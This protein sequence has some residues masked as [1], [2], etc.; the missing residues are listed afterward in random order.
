MLGLRDAVEAD[1]ERV[2][3]FRLVGRVRRVQGRVGGGVRA[4]RERGQGLG[5]QGLGQLLGRQV[6]RRLVGGGQQGRRVGV[7]AVAG[8]AQGPAQAVQA[9]QQGALG[10]LGGSGVELLQRGRSAGRAAGLL[11]YGDSAGEVG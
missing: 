6:V 9:G 1:D 11:G 3:E 7:G 2:S 10:V 5:G 4:V 8:Q